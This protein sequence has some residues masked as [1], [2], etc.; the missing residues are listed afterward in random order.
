MASLEQ[1]QVE[2]ALVHFKKSVTLS[3]EIG[4]QLNGTQTTIHLGWAY[5]AMRSNDEAKNLYLEAYANAQAAKWTPIVLNALLSFTEIQNGLSAKIKL[6]VALS[7][8][9]H[10]AATPNIHTRCESMRDKTKME[11]SIEEINSAENIAKGKSLEDWA[12]ELL[13]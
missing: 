1:G 4:D 8:L 11:L 12:Q 3:K 10:P 9:S 2:E 7:I 6:A 5:A 13:T